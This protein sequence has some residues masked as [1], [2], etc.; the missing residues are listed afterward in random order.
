VLE[1]WVLGLG[2]LGEDDTSEW[3]WRSRQQLPQ[4]NSVAGA[5]EYDAELAGNRVTGTL[6]TVAAFL[7]RV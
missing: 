6:G 3:R 1:T 5:R 2:A 4:P 7:S